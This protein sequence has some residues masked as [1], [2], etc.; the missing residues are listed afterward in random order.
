VAAKA[1]FFYDYMWGGTERMA[2]AI[3]EGAL[4]QGDVETKLFHVRA[5]NRAILAAEI[6]DAAVIAVGSSTLNRTLLPEMA[7]VLTYL[8]GL[9]P[10]R[11]KGFVFG[12]YGWSKGAEAEMAR[13]LQEMKCE[14]VREPLLAQYSPNAGDLEECR[15]AGRMLARVAAESASLAVGSR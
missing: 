6:L 7:G 8:Q 15:E 11:K 12:C 9:R 14:V 5:T 3:L 4:E 1:L 10:P 13:Y 2:R